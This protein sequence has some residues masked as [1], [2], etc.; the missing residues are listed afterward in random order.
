MPTIIL[1]KKDE[2]FIS[3]A[4]QGIHSFMMLGVVKN[5][6][7]Q[8]LA[9]V[10]K[11]NDIDPDVSSQFAMIKKAITTKT[12]SRI[13]DEGLSRK[14]GSIADIS[15]QA[16]AINYEQV[17]EFLGMIAEIEQRQ[18]KNPE[19]AKGIQREYG[20]DGI[21][22]KAIK[23]F[24]PVEEG[25]SVVKFELKKLKECEFLTT[26]EIKSKTSSEIV[27]GV[28]QIHLNNTCRTSSKNIVEAILGFATDVSSYF[29]IAPKHQSKLIVGKPQK[30]SFYVLPPPP[31]CANVSKEQEAALKKIYKRLEEIPKLNPE[32]AETRKKFDA[33][34]SMYKDIAGENHLSAKALFGKILEHEDKN[35]NSLFEKRSPNF[36]SKLFSLSSST[37]RMFDDMENGLKKMM[38]SQ[39]VNDVIEKFKI[40]KGNPTEENSETEVRLS[41]PS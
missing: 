34:K 21:E 37:K 15:Y 33:L 9:R 29:F 32:S 2:Y 7:P 25:K 26:E 40:Q 18:L 12:L 13:A 11:T 35:Q 30:E 8:L 6:Q 39:E 17:K 19:I 36:L 31:N 16:F 28:Q 38:T 14:K 41:K 5:G 22:E 20:S 3:I 27:S 23:C 24:V 10:G 4:K 1:N